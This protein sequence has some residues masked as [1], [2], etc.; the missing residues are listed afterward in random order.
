[1]TLL[2]AF[3]KKAVNLD[4]GPAMI[5]AGPGSGKTVVIT[6]RAAWLIDRMQVPPEQIMVATFSKAAALQM[7]ERFLLLR[8]SQNAGDGEKVTFGTLHAL[9]F[10]ILRASFHYTADSIMKEDQKT[11]LLRTLLRRQ[12]LEREDENALIYSVANEISRVKNAQLPL[13][14][15]YA[16]SCPQDLFRAVFTAYEQALDAG[17]RLDFDDMQSK[18]FA[19][20]SERPDILKAWQQRFSHFLIDE[21]Q[22]INLIQMRIM[23]LLAG[24]SGNLYVVGDDDQ[25][26]YRFRG[27]NPEIML[28]F[29]Q[30][31]PQAALAQL[32]DNFRSGAPIMRDARRLIGHNRRRFEKQCVCH[33][34]SEEEPEYR[35]FSDEQEEAGEICLQIRALHD[36]GVPWKQMAVIT[37]TNALCR[38]LLERALRMQIPVVCRDRVPDQFDHWIAGDILAYLRLAGGGRERKDFLRVC[39][40]PVRY[41]SREC[42]DTSAVSF[43]RLRMWYEEKPWMIR[44]LDEMEEDLDAMSRM[45]PYAAVNYLRKGIGYDT[46]VHDYACAHSLPEEELTDILD[47]LQEYTKPYDTYASLEESIAS[48]R[49]AMKQQNEM[50]ENLRS[51]RDAVVFSTYHSVKGLEFD[52]VWLPD[53]NEGILPYRRAKNEAETEEER[54]LLYVGMTRAKRWL[55]LFHVKK[56]MGKEREPSRFLKE[57]SG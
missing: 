18:C 1:M 56:L 25:S 34:L 39:N 13:E 17:G 50:P 27:A 53:L 24:D 30:V 42:V 4:P 38:Y 45:T 32:Q 41:I 55:H 40:R 43:D 54:R 2:T 28:R 21:F 29:R 48:Y 16:R 57:I 49:A 6:H 3:Q 26:I 33:S 44:R 20:L 9:F 11:Q 14:H 5:L 37:R 8:V 36:E 10:T 22:D 47:E 12:G 46:Y 52:A 51:G 31:Y 35:V 19:L 15:Y 7:K 23:Q